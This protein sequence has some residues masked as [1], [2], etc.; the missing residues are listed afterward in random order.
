MQIEFAEASFEG[1]TLRLEYAWLNREQHDAPLIVFLH[2][3]LG[4]LAMWGGFPQRLCDAGDISKHYRGKMFKMH[5]ES[6]GC[7]EKRFARRDYELGG[8]RYAAALGYPK[9]GAELAQ[10]LA[11]Q[12][13]FPAESGH[14]RFALQQM[15]LHHLQVV[16]QRVGLGGQARPAPLPAKVFS[17]SWQTWT[18]P[19]I[20]AE[21]LS[22]KFTPA[23]SPLANLPFA[24]TAMARR[25][26]ERSR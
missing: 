20:S 7:H 24:S 3:G 2:E 26:R 9:L 5:R 11:Q 10:V 4:T 1:R 21:S 22:A 12:A 17:F 18:I 25:S 19:I 23:K 8:G 15:P 13:G 16:P 6:I 14:C